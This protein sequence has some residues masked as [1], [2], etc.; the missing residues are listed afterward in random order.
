[1]GDLFSSL[2]LLNLINYFMT[3]MSDFLKNKNYYPFLGE[4][5]RE[6]ET[7]WDER[8]KTTSSSS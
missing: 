3:S 4:E 7:W 8:R 2:N 6:R 1:M 5:K